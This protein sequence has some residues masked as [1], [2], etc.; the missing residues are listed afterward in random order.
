MDLIIIVIILV[1]FYI[2]NFVKENFYNFVNVPAELGVPIDDIEVSPIVGIPKIIHHICPVDFK[3]WN[4]KWLICYESWLRLFPKG[5]YEHMHWDD[6]DLEQ[7]ISKNYPWFLEVF[8][9]YDVNI[10]R[11]D[12]ARVFLLYHYGGIYA[13]MDYIVYK[14]FFDELPQDKVSIPESPYKWNEHIQ[15]SFMISPPK[16]N[17]WLVVIDEC[18]NRTQ[19]NV[20]SATGPQ[21]LTPMYFKF[22]NLVNV[23]PHE[24]YNPNV[25]DDSSYDPEKIYAK[26]LLTTVWQK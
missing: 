24:L 10:K 14:N 5:E 12:I 4:S 7:F 9:N 13:D 19:W 16:H 18:Y 21:L 22:P 1:I 8:V 17:F 2:L 11:Y 15:N 26:H 3:K 20:F 25:Y 23:L 6:E